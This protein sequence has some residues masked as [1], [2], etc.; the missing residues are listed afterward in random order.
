MKRSSLWMFA[1]LF[2]CSISLAFTSCSKD[3]DN[4]VDPPQPSGPVVDPSVEPLDPVV[5]NA[6][7]NLGDISNLPDELQ[8]VLKKRFPNLVSGEEADI[9]FCNAEDAERSNNYIQSGATTV[10]I[11]PR[12]AVNISSG[13]IPHHSNNN[14]PIMFYAIQK[15]GKHYAVM[16]ELPE[17][18]NTTEEKTMFYEERVIRLV[19]WLNDVEE[20]K[21]RRLLQE[22]DPLQDQEPYNYEELVSNIDD[23]GLHLT[24]NCPMSL[25]EIIKTMG[26]SDDYRIKASSSVDFGLRVYPIYKQSCNGDQSGDYYVVTAEITPYNQGMWASWHDGY[27]WDEL[28]LMGYWFHKMSTHFKLVDMDG[29]EPAGLDYNRSPLP[30]NDIDSHTYSSGT[31]T[32]IGGSA[33]AGFTPAGGTGSL[34][35]SFSHTVTSNVSYSMDDIDHT[36]DSSTKEVTFMYQSKGVSPDSDDDVDKHYPKNCRTQWTVR[37]AWVWFVPNGSSGVGDNSNA[38]FQIVLNSRLDYRSYWWLWQPIIPNEG[39]D[40]ATYTP[41]IIENQTWQLQ[42]P[43]RQTWGLTSIKSEY[44]DVVMTNIKYYKTGY[45]DQDPVAVDDMSYHQND[46][47][48]MGLPDGTKDGT[49]YTIIYETKNPNT[50]EH[51][52]F[53]KFENVEVHQGCTKDDATTSLSSV[54]A[55]KID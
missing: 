43:N 47:A 35:L 46:F 3:D 28:Y 48:L 20:F 53:W 23:E 15:Y 31:S 45:E 25:N 13:L 16:G 29:N 4:V 52:G 49:T 2:V 50:G 19:H 30:E 14:L 42:A 1:T 33:T 34:S 27:A 12:S 10:M 7:V 11:L 41:G 39:G 5:C 55:T 6:K 24:Y 54:N 40:I 22:T 32:T 51:T 18:F 38:T 36:L 8:T 37:Q 44:T 26:L 21:Q 17:G 9:C